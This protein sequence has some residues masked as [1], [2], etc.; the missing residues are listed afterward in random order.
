MSGV[1]RPNRT[2]DITGGWPDGFRCWF[3]EINYESALKIEKRSDKAIIL[4]APS[5]RCWVSRGD[6]ATSSPIL[7]VCKI[8]SPSVVKPDIKRESMSVTVI[9]EIEYNR[10]TRKEAYSKAIQI[11]ESII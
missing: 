9:E 2:L 6:Y 11:F 7:V 4:K 5:R 1:I 8:E 10:Q 3:R